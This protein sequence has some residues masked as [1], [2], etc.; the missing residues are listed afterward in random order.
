[1]GKRKLRKI[2]TSDRV[3]FGIN[4]TLTKSKW[5]ARKNTSG[6]Q[7]QFVEKTSVHENPLGQ[8]FKR[9]SIRSAV[10]GA[11]YN[12]DHQ[13]KILRGD[14]DLSGRTKRADRIGDKDEYNK[15]FKKI[16][17]FGG[18]EKTKQGLPVPK[19]FKKTYK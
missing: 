1:M 16:K 17:G 3:D 14:F 15:N 9:R 11:S 7:S 13:Q 4:K 18:R 2:K 12:E 8:K 10:H 6:S 19:K 5:K